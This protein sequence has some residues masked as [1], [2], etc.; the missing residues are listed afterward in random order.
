MVS[1]GDGP[2]G[3][4]KVGCFG[5][6]SSKTALIPIPQFSKIAFSSIFMWNVDYCTLFDFVRRLLEKCWTLWTLCQLWYKTWQELILSKGWPRLNRLFTDNDNCFELLRKHILNETG[7][8]HLKNAFVTFLMNMWSLSQD[9][10]YNFSRH[11]TVQSN[12][13]VDTWLYSNWC[14][15]SYK[16][17]FSYTYKYK[18]FEHL[19]FHTVELLRTQTIHTPEFIS[20]TC[21]VPIIP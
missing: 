12:T 4:S 6:Q 16:W 10:S 17:A 3:A 7:Y 15:F 20:V 11:F 14:V 21:H 18:H 8:F 5:I 13:I 2:I 19:Y 1:D 9:F